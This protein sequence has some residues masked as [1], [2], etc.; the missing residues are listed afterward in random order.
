MKRLLLVDDERA[1]VDGL[2]KALRP[3]RE[4]WDVTT[5]VGGRAALEL[6]ATQKF[7]A[8][9]SD[10]RMPDVDG[11]AVLEAARTAQP[12]AVRLVLSGQ[13]DARTGHRLASVAHQF[14]V[15]P[16]APT[17]VMAA[18]EDCVASCESL[19][20]ERARLLVRSV[21]SLPVAPRVYHRVS[22]LIDTP[23][24]D[25]QDVI[26]VVAEDVALVASVLRYANSAF[27]ASPRPVADVKQAVLLVG[28]ERLRELVLLSELYSKPDV[29][30]ILDGLRRRALVRARLS[31]LV[32]EGSPVMH[33][34]AEAALMA[35]VGLYAMAWRM[36]DA[37]TELTRRLAAGETP[38]DALEL[39]LLGVET[40]EVG[41]AL[42]QQWGIPQTVVTAV[43]WHRQ[44]PRDGAALDARTATALAAALEREERD[45]CQAL[46]TQLAEQLGFG[47]KLDLW[48]DFVRQQRTLVQEKAA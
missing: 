14:L 3:W 9:V 30:N 11:E 34:A 15:K 27:F 42:L 19:H 47:A 33:L 40:P 13:V 24:T 35:E 5:A 29:L 37:W 12:E 44:P 4:T 16:S 22:A 45:G 17:A 23:Q 48:R 8:I 28:L 2:R 31:R 1:L 39:E 41:A 20:S 38:Q 10:A 18:V 21:T 25:V 26:D 36:P 7:D 32:T 46:T 43:R 6:L